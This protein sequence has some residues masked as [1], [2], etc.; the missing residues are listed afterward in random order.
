MKKILMI[1]L[2]PLFAACSKYPENAV[3]P[4]PAAASVV[5][6]AKKQGGPAT[7]ATYQL[8]SFSVTKSQQSSIPYN[9]VA[10]TAVGETNISSYDVEISYGNTTSFSTHSSVLSSNSNSSISRSVFTY[11]SNGITYFRLKVYHNNNTIT[12]ST[13]KK[14]VWNVDYSNW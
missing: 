6:K 12:Y 8:V 14:V 2:L 11:A 7:S 10:W 3:C 4:T 13:I 5:V 1:A 9:T